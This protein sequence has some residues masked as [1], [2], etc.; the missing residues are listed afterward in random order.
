MKKKYLII[1]SA[2]TDDP[3]THGGTT[4]L[5]TQ[6]LEYFEK[7]EKDYIFI[8]AMKYEGKFAFVLNYFY[9][10]F[11]LLLNIRKVDLVMI[12]VASRGAYFLA[13]L[14][15]FISHIFKKKFIFR[16]F[17]GN[18]LELYNKSKGLKKK[19]IEY[20]INRADIMFFE[21]KYLVEHYAEMRPNVFWFPNIRKKPTVYRD[22]KR[23][24]QNKLVYLGQIRASKGLDELLEASKALEDGYSIDLY[25]TLFDA[26]YNESLLNQYP[27]ITYRGR[28][29]NDQVYETLAQYDILLLPSYMEGYP[30]VLIE[31]FGVGLPVISTN[32]PSIREMVDGKN[33]LLVDPR[34][35]AQLLEAIKSFNK[36][37]YQEF[38]MNALEKFNHYEYE[39][40]YKNITD[41]CEKDL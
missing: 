35:S 27:N 5:V 32:L 22:I 23:P 4:L 25:G 41:L 39:S 11:K 8:Q 12:H 36:D 31:S 34:N 14:V 33:G 13:P 9:V 26:K 21:P 30:G 37:N 38:A 2:A 29:H 24:Y 16:M 18:F 17:G 20:V 15:L 6:I 19:L 40:V 3:K 10:I 28:V 7:N 1:G